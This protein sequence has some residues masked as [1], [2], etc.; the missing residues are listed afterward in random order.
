MIDK[1]SNSRF[2][3]AVLSLQHVKQFIKDNHEDYIKS[4]PR[5]IYDIV[6]TKTFRRFIAVL[7]IAAM[8]LVYI[9]TRSILL[10]LS[11]IVAPVFFVATPYLCRSNRPIVRLFFV[12]QMAFVWLPCW[13]YQTYLYYHLSFQNIYNIGLVQFTFTMIWMFTFHGRYLVSFAASS[14][15][16]IVYVLV[17][18]RIDPEFITVKSLGTYINYLALGAFLNSALLGLVRFKFYASKKRQEVDSILEYTPQGIF[19]VYNEEHGPIMIGAGRSKAFDEIFGAKYGSAAIAFDS[20]LR[21]CSIAEAELSQILS[22][23]GASIGED[24]FSYDVNENQLPRELVIIK[25]GKEKIIAMNWAPM[26]SAVDGIVN[27]ILVSVTDLTEQRNAIREN[28]EI[29][30]RQTCLAQL[31]NAGRDNCLRF[32]KTWTQQLGVVKRL[33]RGE[34][35][36]TDVKQAFIIVHS[37]KGSAL[38]LGLKLIADAAHE[39]ETY[40][41]RHLVI[42]EEREDAAAL[43]AC[44]KRAESSLDY[45][46]SIMETDL[47]WMSED[48]EKLEIDGSDLSFI[49]STQQTIFHKSLAERPG[50]RLSKAMEQNYP[51]LFDVVERVFTRCRNTAETLEKPVPRLHVQGNGI[52]LYPSTVD[53]IESAFMH[54]VNNAIDHGIEDV[55]SRRAACK[56]DEGHIIICVTKVSGR[57][58]ISCSDDGRGI[59]IAELRKKAVERGFSEEHYSDVEIVELFFHS[60]FTTKD[61]VTKIS[62]RGIGLSAVAEGF[63]DLGAKV[64]FDLS[65]VRSPGHMNFVLKIDFPVEAFFIAD[66]TEAYETVEVMH[67]A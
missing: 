39:F 7:G 38:T 48:L 5:L 65:Q 10:S 26:T 34:R 35:P 59:R 25:D 61:A 17:V 52:R 15:V 62:G 29:K 13:V 50:S 14:L 30:L 51:L 2:E 45:Y 44:L 67:S 33:M 55:A 36:V 43:L 53:V 27:A 28:Q 16:S 21:D 60:G 4:Y 57:V 47:F 20:F 24:S 66:I 9:Q 18:G 31:T 49:V 19:R 37:L 32:F 3:D 63:A 46:T 11:Q 41:S 1:K 64:S 40:L 23:V 22:R 56:S 58:T 42:V 8:V 6:V 54:I 12:N